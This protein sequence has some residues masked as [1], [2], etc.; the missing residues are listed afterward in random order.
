MTLSKTRRQKLEAMAA[1]SESP[2]EALV[3]Q[4]KLAETGTPLERIAAQIKA[5]WGKGIETQFAIGR[6][7]IEAHQLMPDDREYGRWFA[8]QHFP[9]K[10]GT[11]F[12]LQRGAEREPEVRALMAARSQENE[13]DIGVPYAI[14]LLDA[15]KPKPQA[16]AIPVTDATP[17]DPAYA[18]IRQAY[19]VIAQVQ[20]GEPTGNGFLTMHVEDL[21]KSAQYIQK[22][23][24]LYA[25]A[26]NARS[27]SR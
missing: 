21:V 2:N 18:A 17:A 14:Q 22:L 8:D 20:E 10:K 7:L 1:Q 23:A 15:P 11:A 6:L 12:L 3:A 4:A 16:E 13:R 27:S 26:K 25:E 9:F 5:E 19:N 24:G